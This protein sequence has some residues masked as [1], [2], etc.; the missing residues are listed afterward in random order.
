MYVCIY[1]YI[2]IDRCIYCNN[3]SVCVCV[4]IYMY[5]YIH[6][7]NQIHIIIEHN[8]L[9][10]IL[11]YTTGASPWTAAPRRRLALA[12]APGRGQMENLSHY[13]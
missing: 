13:L 5:I 3:I 6:I 9:C 2:C 1:I 8:N 10:I 11:Y 4:H 12:S 7:H